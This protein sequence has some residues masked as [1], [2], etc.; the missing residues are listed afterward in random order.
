[1]ARCPAEP[2]AVPQPVA[3][4][5]PP[6]AFQLSPTAV[7]RGP[8]PEARVTFPHTGPGGQADPGPCCVDTRKGGCFRGSDE[9]SRDDHRAAAERPSPGDDFP[10]QDPG[11]EGRQSRPPRLVRQALGPSLARV[12]F[13]H[14]GAVKRISTRQASETQRPCV[15]IRKVATTSTYTTSTRAVL[16]TISSARRRRPR[17]GGRRLAGRSAPH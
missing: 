15:G 8:Q 17:R 6:P 11:L 10:R 5:G 2:T 7:V 1:M 13:P 4:C 9:P 16:R 12:T 3:A 14:A